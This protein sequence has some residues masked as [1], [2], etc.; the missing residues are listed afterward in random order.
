MRGVA[1]DTAWV[2]RLAND[3]GKPLFPRALEW[4]LKHQRRDGSWGGG[5]EYYHDRV[6]STLSA[7]N[8]LAGKKKRNT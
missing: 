6:V 3:S 7:V 8:A 1:Y 4:L 5:V 2:A